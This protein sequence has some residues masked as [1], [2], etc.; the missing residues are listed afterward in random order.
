MHAVI[1][2]Y[3][4]AGA[5]ELFDLLEQR[6]SEVEGIMR[7][8]DGFVSY[9]LVRTDSGGTSVTVCRDERGAVESVARARE[10]VQA[11]ADDNGL[12]PPAVSEGQTILYS[13]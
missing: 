1:R 11:N 2:T 12:D 7:S 10:W 5:R 4:G 13:R 6:T 3:S 9:L 8:I